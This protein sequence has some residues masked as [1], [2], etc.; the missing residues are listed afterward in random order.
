MVSGLACAHLSSSSAKNQ[1]D[2]D[3]VRYNEEV[4][5][6]QGIKERGKNKER[7]TEKTKLK[8]RR[9]KGRPLRMLFLVRS[10]VVMRVCSRGAP[11]CSRS[12]TT[13]LVLANFS[14]NWKGQTS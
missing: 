1:D 5:R 8:T 6:N 10:S 12:S 11:F 13:D 3:T 7:K 2:R 4:K 9:S 14:C